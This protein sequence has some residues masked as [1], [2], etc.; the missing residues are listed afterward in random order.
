MITVAVVITGMAYS[1]WWPPVVR[2]HGGYWTI[3][4]DIWLE[5]RDAHYVGWGGLSFVYSAHTDLVTLPGFAVIMWPVVTLC[6]ALGL[7]ESA[8]I[9][10][11]TEPHAWFLVGPFSMAM[12]GVA[13]FALNAL[14]R[15]LGISR[16]SRHVL[17]VVE[18]IALWSTVDMWGHPEDVVALGFAVYALIFLLDR[19]WTGAGWFL[20]IAI[21][22]QLY[23]VVLIP[24]VI[25]LIGW[26]KATEV[27]A[28]S[29]IIPGFFLVA[30][31]VPNFHGS[32]TALLNQPNFPKANFPTPWVLLAP[33]LSSVTVAAG[34]GRIIGLVVAVALAIPAYRWRGNPAAVV[35]LAG[36]VLGVRCIFESVMD[37]YYVMPAL[38]LALVA[39]ATRGRVRWLLTCV[40]GLGLSLILYRHINMWAYWF[41]MTGLMT[42]MFAL[43]WPSS[44]SEPQGLKEPGKG[45]TELVDP[46]W[47]LAMTPAHRSSAMS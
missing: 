8:P 33:K 14:A 7:S 18:G 40:F 28:R 15:R 9:L 13:L 6:S 32:I 16:T 45:P 19:R 25:A 31:L 24:I 43:A 10:Q 27:L 36:V 5:V 3:P 47:D 42:A 1:F 12:T 29:A 4:T 20:G 22:M 17:M 46:D 44:V 38:A 37:P 21:A 23:V 11:L 34:P 41:A 35:W 30:V 26:R 39:G 2:H